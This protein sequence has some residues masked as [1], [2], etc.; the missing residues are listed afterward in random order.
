MYSTCQR[1]PTSERKMKFPVLNLTC[2]RN[3][4]ISSETW[5]PLLSHLSS[6]FQPRLPRGGEVVLAFPNLLEQCLSKNICPKNSIQPNNHTVFGQ[7]FND[8][9]PYIL[10]D[11]E[12]IGG[13]EPPQ[14]LLAHMS[15]GGA[16]YAKHH[17]IEAVEWQKPSMLM[18]WQ[19]EL[20]GWGN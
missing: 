2:T 7:K 20:R 13:G 10:P 18:A 17:D 1:N 14:S 6:A 3:D 11:M 5:V 8:I 19:S 4:L 12:R 15:V 16:W 9:L